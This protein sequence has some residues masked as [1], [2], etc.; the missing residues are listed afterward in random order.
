MS[1][2][3]MNMILTKK[4][5]AWINSITDEKVKELATKNTII[6]GGAIASMLL[7]EEIHDFDF[8]FTD[9]ETCKAI[10]DY[11]V[12]QFI[13]EH[14]NLKIKPQ[15]AIE[16]EIKCNVKTNEGKMQFIALEDAIPR[17]RIRIQSAGIV[18]DKT[19][20]ANYQYFE[21]RP[22][23]E[24]E[25]YVDQ[26]V[27]SPVDTLEKQDSINDDEIQ[28]S[29][30]LGNLR[31]AGTEKG[32]FRPVFLTD[33]AITLSD[34]TQ[35][36]IRFYGNAEK[37]HENFDY[38]HCT[39]Y[40]HS[41]TKELVL[42]QD[43]LE[44]LLA[45]RLYY[46]NSK[47]PICAL[48]RIRKFLKRGFTIDAGQILKMCFQISKLDLDNVETLNDQLL[49]MDVAYFQQLINYIQQEKAKDEK[50]ILDLPYLA[51]IIDRIF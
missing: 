8:Y 25:E 31:G 23:N 18:G 26:A 42:R 39:N 6:T 43:A 27:E 44:S 45:K 20:D 10:A 16:N 49:G 11:Y 32:K 5:E 21:N 34:K 22:L 9:F 24:G 51:S 35:L 7:K 15:V 19:N 48:V 30:A 37:I 3:I 28:K 14:D 17:V 4:H 41:D 13:R 47:Y 36:I 29:T 38:V 46:V 12:Q 33:N 2:R 1:K 40:W 50:W